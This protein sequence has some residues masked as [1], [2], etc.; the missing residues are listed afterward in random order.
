M[1]PLTSLGLAAN[2]LQFVEFATKLVGKASDIHKSAEGILPENSELWDITTRLQGLTQAINRRS[3]GPLSNQNGAETRALQEV[4]DEC[5]KVALELNARFSKLATNGRMSRFKS[6]R[7]ALKS[8]WNKEAIDAL[9]KRLER[10]RG[11]INTYLLSAIRNDMNTLASRQS[12]SLNLLLGEAI[13]SHE[14]HQTTQK[15]VQ[16]EVDKL[17]EQAIAQHKETRKQILQAIVDLA[18]TGLQSRYPQGFSSSYSSAKRRAEKIGKRMILNSLA[19]STMDRRFEAVPDAHQ[20]TFEWVFDRKDYF[21]ADWDNFAQWT[22]SSNGLY[23]I[24]GKAGSGKSTLMKF[25][26]LDGRT[27]QYLESWAGSDQLVISHHFFWRKGSEYQ[28][29]I[30]G[31]LRALLVQTFQQKPELLETVLG[32]RLKSL[33]EVIADHLYL[34]QEGLEEGSELPLFPNMRDKLQHWSMSDLTEALR[35]L[36]RKNV[37]D[38]RFCFLVDGLDEFDGDHQEVIQLLRGLSLSDRIKI[39]VSSRPLPVFQKALSQYPG[40][41]LQDLT[42]DDIYLVVE[43]KLL[44]HPDMVRVI[45]KSPD[46]AMK[47]ANKIVYKASGV[48]LWVHLVIKSLINGLINN[49]SINDLEHRL[50]ILPPDLEDLYW[51]M[52]RNIDAVYRPQTAMVFRICLQA[53]Q[54]VR[55]LSLSFAE[56]VAH[57]KKIAVRATRRDIP[58]WECNKRIAEVAIRL[59]SVCAGLLEIQEDHVVFLHRTVG[60]FFSKPE[61][62]QLLD[63]FV[64]GSQSNPDMIIIHASILELKWTAISSGDLFWDIVEGALCAGTRADLEGEDLDLDL[65]HE[66]DQIVTYRWTKV[67]SFYHAIQRHWSSFIGKALRGPDSAASLNQTFVHCAVRF[68]LNSYLRHRLDGDSFN[69]IRHLEHPLLSTAIPAVLSPRNFQTSPA[70]QLP[71]ASTVELLLRHGASP[72]VKYIDKTPWENA[73]H[74]LFSD[75]NPHQSDVISGYDGPEFG[76]RWYNILTLLL[77]YG[78]DPH[79]PFTVPT[80]SGE[81][82]VR[83][84][85]ATARDILPHFHKESAL[86]LE[87]CLLA[88]GVEYLSETRS[89]KSV[90][91]QM[92]TNLTPKVIT[93]K[94][95]LLRQIASAP[96]VRQNLHRAY[97]SESGFFMNLVE[98]D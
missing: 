35:S 58:E 65:M 49:D 84:S 42:E 74:H 80:L 78:A 79:T 10:F 56:E 13:Q 98:E 52:L 90:T 63:E 87:K 94:Q 23:W 50:D 70:P 29:S 57:G 39:C 1:D 69:F 11:E 18:Q 76:L 20:R 92:N 68:Q 16:N 32:G 7:Q 86:T 64:S 40:L 93:R 89:G 2:L 12:S 5:N 33:V 73:L 17:E 41:R 54:P 4:C 6:Y 38:T 88:R 67:R 83:S 66:F 14:E 22:T 95:G 15:L 62:K 47:I 25:V 31:L 60:D 81:V 43:G 51:H 8:V 19:F 46:R 21:R 45:E 34:T 96:G 61:V 48:F 28:R 53:Q 3:E 82:V 24:N 36:T 71:S 9:F 37:G 75:Y 97:K 27:R 30:P 72:N 77:K 44:K 55:A 91:S 59:Q 85:L 26:L